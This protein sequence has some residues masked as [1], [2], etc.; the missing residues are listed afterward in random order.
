[1]PL[2]LPSSD[3]NNEYTTS[4]LQKQLNNKTN[5]KTLT[6]NKK[7]KRE[8]KENCQ[9]QSTIPLKLKI[10]LVGSGCVGKSSLTIQVKIFNIK[11]FICSLFNNILSLN[12]TQPFLIFI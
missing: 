3:L 5:G 11:L 2:I 12:M 6:K 10:V 4:S 9:K 1:M 8:Q 7:Q